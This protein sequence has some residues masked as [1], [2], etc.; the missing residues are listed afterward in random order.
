[1]I[2]VRTRRGQVILLT[3][4][5]IGGMLFGATVIGG[6]LV[7]HQIRQSSDAANSAKAIFAADTGIEW[8]LYQFFHATT[9][10]APALTNGA[11]F[12][13]TCASG[14]SGTNCADASTTI[15]K[16]LG[17]SGGLGRAL[18]FSL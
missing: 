8:G 13:L 1:M 9:T 4:L 11:S 10:A 17:A 16:A 6:T 15:I 12:V 18:E 7:S 3:L 5:A 14:D 2:H